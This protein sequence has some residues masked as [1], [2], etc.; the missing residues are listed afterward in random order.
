MTKIKIE[1]AIKQSDG[2]I[3]KIDKELKVFLLKKHGYWE[4]SNISLVHFINLGGEEV[5]PLAQW[6][7]KR[8]GSKHFSVTPIVSSFD[9]FCE[10][11]GEKKENFSK[12]TMI[13]DSFNWD[14]LWSN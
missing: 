10:S 9:S 3:R 4:E 2:Y 14:A 11:R 1:A 5:R 8:R 7:Y 12:Y 6:V 13:Q